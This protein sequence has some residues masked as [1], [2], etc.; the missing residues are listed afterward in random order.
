MIRVSAST[1]GQLSYRCVPRSADKRR[2]SKRP[3]APTQRAV[4]LGIAAASR[5]SLPGEARQRVSGRGGAIRRQSLTFSTPV[6]SRGA[7]ERSHAGLRSPTA[8]RSEFKSEV[9]GTPVSKRRRFICLR[10]SIWDWSARSSSSRSRSLSCSSLCGAPSFSRQMTTAGS[11][12]SFFYSKPTPEAA[13]PATV[14]T[15]LAP[16]QPMPSEHLRRLGEVFALSDDLTQALNA[17]TEAMSA[18]RR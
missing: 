11:P 10:L 8:K 5:P 7:V 1:V 4:R 3:T 2:A 18:I 12:R 15:P 14:P 17:H 13:R 9:R 6:V 16:P